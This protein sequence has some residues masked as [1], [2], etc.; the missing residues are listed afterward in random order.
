[1]KPERWS[2]VE[3]IF[4]KALEAEESRRGFVIEE[5]CAGDAELRREV[6]SL[7]AHHSDSASFIEQP[8]FADPADPNR[9]RPVTAAAAPRPDLK[10]VAVGHY[11]ILEEIGFGGMGVV[12]KAEDTRLGRL[13]A[14]K[15]LPAH[16]A[17][18]SVALERFR[19]EARAASSLNH[20]NICTI[21]DIDEYEARE[22]IVM[23]YLDGQTL[24]MYIAGRRGVGTELVAKL[25]M[26]IAEALGAA[27]SKGVIHRDIK[28]ANI[29][30][31]QSGLVKVLDFGVAKLVA[32]AN[33]SDANTLTEANAVTGTL[34]Y[35]SPEQLRGE[36]LDARSDI[37][38]LG[39]VLYEIATGQRLYS[40]SLHARL[41]DEILNRPASPP[42]SIN[43][44]LSAKA[45]DI[46]LK[47][48]AKDPEDRYYTAD[49]IAVDLRHL[50]LRA[51]LQRLQR[52]SHTGKAPVAPK[53]KMKSPSRPA[54]YAASI[55]LIAAAFA[56]YL[57]RSQSSSIRMNPAEWTQITDFSDSVV[58]PALS[59]DGHI[60][61]FIRGNDPFFGE[62]QIYA[63]LLPDGEAV[64]LTH[65]AIPKMSPRFSPDGSRIYYTEVGNSWEIWMV[66]VLGGEP[67]LMLANAEG[68]SWIGEHSI[69]F[70]E[71]KSGLHMALETAN[72][73]RTGV[74]DIYVPPRERGM[75][76]RSALSPDRKSVLLTEMDNGGWLPC[77]LLPFDGSSVGQRVGPPGAECVDVAWSP[78]GEWMYFSANPGGRFHIWRQRYPAGELQQV[79]SGATEEEGI[80]IAP[81][82]DSLITSVGT[83]QRVVILH[84]A[85]GERQISS[86]S[87][88]ESA[89]FS[90]DGK[91]VFYTVP[92][93]APVGQAVTGE[94]VFSVDL[95]T[96]QGERVLAGVLITGY[97]TS[98]DGKRIVYSA[99]D[100]NHHPHLWQADLDLHS[101]PQ[102]F[103]SPSDE[104]APQFGA[105][106]FIYFRA[107]EGG[108]NFLYR[109]KQD[110]S[111]RSKL[112]QQ[113]INEVHGISPDGK[114]AVVFPPLVRTGPLDFR[115]EIVPLAGG[116]PVTVCPTLCYSFWTDRGNQFAVYLQQT[117]GY[118]TVLLPIPPGKV[119]PVL[120]KGGIES[121]K[122]ESI[123]KGVRVIDGVAVLGPNAGEYVS[124]RDSVHR[125]LY[126]IPLK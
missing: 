55:V 28:P 84:D 47:C 40:S 12:Y 68:L 86:E 23:E 53:T 42:S 4:N 92:E 99:L 51:D 45:D 103:M 81:D 93:R 104:D 56:I 77:R 9:F 49:E 116:E 89:S 62:G 65:D 74:R 30:V 98:P 6:E 31:T 72:E 57:F 54:I 105:D 7:L 22:F 78:D 14:L 36:N 25:G 91:K 123:G 113:S 107:A 61:A 66:P 75:A 52:E 35:M 111:G 26:P 18:D 32:E 60:L 110:G 59:P 5:S 112:L 122:P 126:R 46:I 3:S 58:S 101:S 21:Y 44:K 83:T 64:Q 37:Y 76:H 120:P 94:H 114:W 48:L 70:S 115:T 100:K 43:E 125:N 13:V 63:K 19:R 38:A 34:A 80:A 20:P 24:A 27:H 109:M 16:L 102:Q 1:M 121:A 50:S 67:R 17:A 95:A 11:R 71:T 41:V 124:L 97:S 118:K 87:Y 119:L 88:A 33:Q 117:N 10:G 2:K 96:G 39:V 73:D 69:L 79:T 15:F 8:A 29:F 82:G 85:Q 108:K 106:G 90:R